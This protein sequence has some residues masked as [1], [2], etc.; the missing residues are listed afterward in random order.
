MAELPQHPDGAADDEP[1][2][3]R[4]GRAYAVAIV[5]VIL[6]AGMLVLHLTGVLGPGSH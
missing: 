3:S 4:S 1:P 6:L 5:V 2:T